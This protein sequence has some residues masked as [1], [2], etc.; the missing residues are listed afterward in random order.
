[1]ADLRAWFRKNIT[2]VKEDA[3]K[4]SAQLVQRLK[5]MTPAEFLRLPA[6]TFASLTAAQ[7]RDIV[8]TIAPDTELPMPAPLEELP[9]DTRTWRDWWRER[10]TLVQV[11]IVT[12][13]VTMLAVGLAIATPWAQNWMASRME[14]V[15]PVSTATWPVCARL[16]PYTD[17]CVYYPRQNLG[18]D[19]VAQQLAMSPQDLYAANR[20]LSPEYIPANS[21]LAVWRHRGRLEK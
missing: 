6:N 2:R 4:T 10:S 21:V 9:A 19:W 3:D 1:M 8:A 12:V 18:W 16:S 14:I 13:M 15:R 7:Y 11:S 5:R 20:H 17:G